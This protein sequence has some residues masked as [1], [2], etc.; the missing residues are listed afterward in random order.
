MKSKLSPIKSSRTVWDVPLSF[1]HRSPCPGAA[2]LWSKKP[3]RLIPI[4]CGQ[5]WCSELPSNVSM[6]VSDPPRCDTTLSNSHAAEAPSQLPISRHFIGAAVMQ[7][8]K[9]RDQSAMIGENK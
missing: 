4:V 7:S 2:M 9:H 5:A 6:Q 1:R 3:S 8:E